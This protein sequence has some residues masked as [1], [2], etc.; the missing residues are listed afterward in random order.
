MYS[1]EIIKSS[2]LDPKVS[3]KFLG[4]PRNQLLGP[5]SLDR[6]HR[7]DGQANS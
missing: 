6:L 5:P 4:A 7:T 2:F 3:S 1:L